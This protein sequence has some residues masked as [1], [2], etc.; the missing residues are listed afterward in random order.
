[1]KF[2]DALKA[3]REGKKVTRKCWDSPLS[4]SELI[5]LR[6]PIT[7]DL[8]DVDDF[9]IIE[10]KEKPNYKTS[11]VYTVC[12]ALQSGNF[13]C[14]HNNAVATNNGLIL[15]IPS[16]CMDWNARE[17]KVTVETID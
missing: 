17:I 5:A 1:M 6:A 10:E 3:M 9:E 7:K 2:E 4:L 13:L 8:L 15:E 16:A 11:A 14:L 12:D